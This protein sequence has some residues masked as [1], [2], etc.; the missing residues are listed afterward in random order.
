MLLL[1]TD[2]LIDVLRG[3]A[4][5]ID[6]FER[7]AE[8][9]SVPG[10]VVMELVQD[11]PD[12]QR[13]RRALDLVSQFPIVW[14]SGADCDRALAT[15]VSLHLSHGLGLIDALIAETAMGRRAM[16]GTFNVKHF[17]HVQGLAI[18]Q[19]YARQP[20]SIRRP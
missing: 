13:L 12:A 17:S 19:P 9:P 16:L 3:H 8:P 7:V 10:F 11:A 15:Y 1:D 18:L 20:G 5:A 4:P 2:V 6:W 14:P